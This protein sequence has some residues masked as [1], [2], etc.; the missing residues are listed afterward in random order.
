MK[1]LPLPLR[2]AAGLAATA[3]EHA[4]DLPAKLAGILVTVA[5]QALHKSM[6]V[7]ADVTELEIKDEEVLAGLRPLEES[8][9]WAAFD[10]DH[11]E[12][13]YDLTR[14]SA[15]DQVADD[16]SVNGHE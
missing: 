16:M 4:R 8:P 13:R 15:F 9:A 12:I 7:Q 2:I 10:E 14:P 6:R 5:N 11:D 1:S 3:V